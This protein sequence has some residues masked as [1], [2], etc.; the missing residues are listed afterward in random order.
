M[1]WETEFVDSLYEKYGFKEKTVSKIAYLFVEHLKMFPTHHE[2]YD[3]FKKH[4]INWVKQS[5]NNGDLKEYCK[6]GNYQ[7][8]N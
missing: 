6:K 1:Y 3:S 7:T 4:Y 5:F 8:N 2:D